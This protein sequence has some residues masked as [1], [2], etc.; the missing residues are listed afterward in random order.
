MIRVLLVVLMWQEHRY[1]SPSLGLTHPKSDITSRIH[2]PLLFFSW[3]NNIPLKD[4]ESL[5]RGL[6]S[7][8]RILLL[9]LPCC[10]SHSWWLN[11][12]SE[13]G[14]KQ[15]KSFLIGCWAVLLYWLLVKLIWQVGG[16]SF[17]PSTLIS[18]TQLA[19]A[20]GEEVLNTKT[21]FFHASK[22]IFSG[23]Q[24]ADGKAEGW[25]GSWGHQR[26]NRLP[27]KSSNSLSILQRWL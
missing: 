19:V 15:L 25:G 22:H 16:G 26:E 10:C 1:L 11:Q 12:H 20:V 13:K 21:P 9:S 4:W 7:R 27:V 3:F 24:A 17:H 14:K 5:Y 18:A 23:G 6:V 8:G 2:I